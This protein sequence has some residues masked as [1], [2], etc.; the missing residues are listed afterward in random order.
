MGDTKNN[1]DTK[2]YE[3]VKLLLGIDDE[4]A[5]IVNLLLNDT[6]NAILSHCRIDEL[7][8][9]L[10]DLVAIIVSKRYRFLQ[11]EGVKTISEG[12]RRVEY[13]EESGMLDEYDERLKPFVS[14]SVKVPSEVS[15]GEVV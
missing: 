9:E 2:I 5:D 1:R 11:Q 10:D 8:E 12:E 13:F 14:R 4:K 6:K 3:N 7:P 15:D